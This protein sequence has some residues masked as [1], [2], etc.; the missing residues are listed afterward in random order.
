MPFY[1]GFKRERS[2][3]MKVVFPVWR[4]TRSGGMKVISKLCDLL[5]QRG[6][7]T[8]IITY[9]K[10][11]NIYYEINVPVVYVGM[12]GKSRD[13]V[14]DEETAKTK[15]FLFADMIKRFVSLKN[16]LNQISNEYNIA[17]A[18]YNLSAYSVACSKVAKKF[19]YIQL[20]EASE[21]PR[22]GYHWIFDQIVKK[23]YKLDLIRIVN[24]DIYKEYK[25]IKAR[26]VLPPGIDLNMF[27]PKKIWWDEKRKF[28]IG[29]IGR[30]EPW[31]GSADVA[32]AVKLLRNKGIEVDFKVAFNKV[33]CD[34]YELIC[35]DGPEQLAS[36]YRG[37]DVLV[38]PGT[39]QLGAVHYPVIEAMACGTPVIT[40]GYYPA[41]NS[42]AYIVPV[43]KPQ[44]IADTIEHIMKYYDEAR[45]KTFQALKDVK[46]FNWEN[47][48]SSLIS[49][50]NENVEEKN[51][52][53]K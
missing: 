26:Y 48:A 37:V 49:I 13:R 11:S 22:K 33:D 41:N 43:S 4:F 30:K 45:E 52:N 28:I 47:I 21:I 2:L 14:V 3:K 27:Y 1:Q 32:S 20:Y 40:T 9:Y 5:Q 51:D 35:A 10:A 8:I 39:I 44:A 34:A 12:N 6:I 46:V 31:K 29:C 36:F 25:E 7:E 38:A 24:A 16:G 23:T 42:N 19:Y 17:I 53:A 18:T 50:I 15:F